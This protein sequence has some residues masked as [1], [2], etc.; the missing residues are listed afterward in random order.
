[1]IKQIPFQTVNAAKF[2]DD[3][4]LDRVFPEGW[5]YVGRGVPRKGLKPSVLANLWSSR[6]NAR[7]IRVSDS[8]TA[9][10]LFKQWLWGQMKAGN[11]DVLNELRKVEDH[12]VLVCHCNGTTCHSFVVRKAAKWLKEQEKQSNG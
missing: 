12:T 5:M 8:K 1:M 10:K 11:E 2:N 3:E 7:A 9:V 6:R 4:H